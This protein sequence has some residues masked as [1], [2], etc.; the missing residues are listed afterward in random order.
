MANEM[1]INEFGEIVRKTGENNSQQL[2]DIP[3]FTPPTT[4]PEQVIPNMSAKDGA[5][6]V[7]EFGEIV[8]GNEQENVQPINNIPTF[9]PPENDG[10]RVE[11]VDP[12]I[13]HN[14]QKE[15]FPETY[16]DDPNIVIEEIKKEETELE[17]EGKD[18]E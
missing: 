8:R 5:V 12:E 16:R 11:H 18:R 13:L 3:T 6:N 7:N 9:T 4:E 2:N 10:P 17:Q 1:E 15:L 14:A